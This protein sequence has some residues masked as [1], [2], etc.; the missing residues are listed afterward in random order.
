MVISSSTKGKGLG[1]DQK[2]NMIKVMIVCQH[3][4]CFWVELHDYGLNKEICVER[5][6]TAEDE[7]E[8]ELNNCLP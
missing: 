1:R 2:N 6:V 3:M 5:V 4:A 8:N 7:P